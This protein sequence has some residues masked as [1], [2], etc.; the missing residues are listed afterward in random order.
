V[1]KMAGWKEH[2]IRF[3]FGPTT[4]N[5]NISAQSSSL[6]PGRPCGLCYSP[7]STYIYI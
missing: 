7:G 6:T 5:W 4:R 3:W 1:V 2:N